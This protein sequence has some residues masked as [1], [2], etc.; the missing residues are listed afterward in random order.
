VL[1]CLG[2]GGGGG[3]GLKRA[4]QLRSEILQSST[5]KITYFVEGTC[6]SMEKGPTRVNWVVS[7]E[8]PW[9]KVNEPGVLYSEKQM[10]G[11]K[12]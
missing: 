5:K 6:R 8:G 11:R 10:K 7:E 9:N 1:A 2:R 3:G 4:R 12:H